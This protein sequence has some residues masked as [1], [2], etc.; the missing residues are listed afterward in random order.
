M[1]K[2]IPI[3]LSICTLLSACTTSP[4]QTNEPG[5]GSRVVLDRTVP[6]PEDVTETENSWSTEDVV[7]AV[8]DYKEMEDAAPYLEAMKGDIEDNGITD[9]KMWYYQDDTYQG[10]AWDVE[11]NYYFSLAKFDAD[12]SIQLTVADQS[13]RTYADQLMEKYDM[14]DGFDKLMSSTPIYER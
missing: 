2:L 12:G 11:G 14:L 4:T 9:F 5:W 6:W 10:L 1:K 7:F 3:L 8:T 13:D